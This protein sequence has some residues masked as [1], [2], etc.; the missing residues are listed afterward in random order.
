VLRETNHLFL[1]QSV[2]APE[3]GRWVEQQTEWPPLVISIARAWLAA[4]LSDRCITRDLTWGIPVPRPGFEGKVFYVWFDAPIGY[5]AATQEWADLDP[6][7]RD[8][9]RWW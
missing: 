7:Q 4:G 2:F 9:R 3:I 1:R 6:T 8:W 5:I